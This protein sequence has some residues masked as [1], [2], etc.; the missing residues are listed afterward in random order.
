[1]AL[2]LRIE[3]WA[4]NLEDVTLD[5]WLKAE[6]ERVEVGD[7]VCEIITDK[8]TFEYEAEVAGTLLKA[9]AAENSVL[10]VGYVFG[11]V[12]EVGEALPDGVEEE[13]QRLLAARREAVVVDL[14]IEV[15]TRAATG[16]KSRVRATP[17]ARRIAREA[18]VRIED[19]GEWLGGDGAVSDDDVRRYVA[20]VGA[21]GTE[22][23]E[24]AE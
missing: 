5:R 7:S 21:S 20:E 2:L 24:E 12:G 11:L 22:S 19:V 3:K 17:V 14:D 6:G 13:N 10:P 1:M 16:G 9:Y 8:A 18:G 23:E 4:E 15:L